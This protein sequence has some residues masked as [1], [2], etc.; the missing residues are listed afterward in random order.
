M[1]CSAGRNTV[2][3]RLSLTPDDVQSVRNG[4]F[5]ADGIE[6]AFDSLKLSFVR[7]S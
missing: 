3:Q 5:L 6:K 4:L 7:S 1:L 2:H